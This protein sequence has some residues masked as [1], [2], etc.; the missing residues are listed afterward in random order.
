MTGSF[1]KR[2]CVWDT[3]ELVMVHAY[4]F[5]SEVKVVKIS[6]VHPQSMAAI[7]TGESQVSLCDLR[8]GNV[9]QSLS[10]HTSAITALAWSPGSEYSILSGAA[11]GSM[12]L[13]DL[14]KSNSMITFD[15]HKT[16]SNPK[17]RGRSGL[18]G[19][20]DDDDDDN[21]G[22]ASSNHQASTFAAPSSSASSN[23][24]RSTTLRTKM[25]NPS[26]NTR[27]ETAHQG[28]VTDLVFLPCGTRILSTGQDHM[29]RLWDESTG[30]NQ[31]VHYPDIRNDCVH[32]ARIALSN[33]GAIVYHPR[34][35]DL[36]ALEVETGRR[37]H[38]LHGH[39]A[40]VTSCTFHKGMPELYSGASD[41][42]MLVWTPGFDE[43]RYIGGALLNQA[44]RG[45]T[46]ENA[47]I[48]ARRRV[49]AGDED[50]LAQVADWNSD[51]DDDIF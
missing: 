28:A 19:P 5:D 50:E 8:L 17:K 38:T 47:V 41:G 12:K 27:P 21:T 26:A 30:L 3:N 1:D 35:N 29:M 9:V 48:A 11:D 4:R 51:E 20:L 25:L 23:S 6:P 32:P 40:N 49:A 18:P 16:M 34:R 31:F 45:G 43:E 39:F 24:S 44:G 13:W 14:R 33:N 7:G 37:I 10:G 42:S 22:E 15:Y 2:A 36:V 46:R